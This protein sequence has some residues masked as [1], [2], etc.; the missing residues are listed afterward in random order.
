MAERRPTDDADDRDATHPDV[1]EQRQPVDPRDADDD[2]LE[3][4]EPLDPDEIE[5]RLDV[6]DDDDGYDRT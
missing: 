4:D 2:P 5:Q 3:T 1:L 6:H